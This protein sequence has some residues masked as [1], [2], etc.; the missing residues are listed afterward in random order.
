MKTLKPLFPLFFLLLIFSS[1]NTSTRKQTTGEGGEK[2]PEASVIIPDFNADSAY[3]FVK[4]Q[5]DFGP[6]V[7]N[8]RAHEMCGNYLEKKLRRYCPD[9]VV[10]KGEIKAY[11]GTMLKFKNIIASFNPATNDRIFLCSHWDSRP[12]ADHDPDAAKHNTPIDGANDGASGVGV[13]LEIARQ[14]SISKPVM[15]VDIILLDAED[16]GPPEDK[17]QQEDTTDWWALG[18]QYWA[19]NPHKGNYFAKYGILLDMVGAPNATFLQEAFSMAYAPSVVKSVWG[20]A[21]KL[22]Y[23]DYFIF[24]EGGMITDDHVPINKIL[25]I[26]TIDIVHLDRIS[27]T[28]FYPYWHTVRDDINSI[29]RTTL[30]VVGTTL[31]KVIESGQ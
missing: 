18:A 15:G 2:K 19:K 12:Y 23:S 9:V 31:L 13:L 1:C 20:T 28:G 10:Q 21:A 24:E 5:V 29:D 14:L 22:G 26:P 11:N 16:Y 17:K 27:K 30:K 6:R 4:T 8:T 7:C 3:Q 25:N